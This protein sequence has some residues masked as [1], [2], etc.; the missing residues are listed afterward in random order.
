MSDER[1][2]ESENFEEPEANLPL[3]DVLHPLS[4]KLLSKGNVSCLPLPDSTAL[5]VQ[6]KKTISLQP[7][8]P[9]LLIGVVT[10]VTDDLNHVHTR[11]EGDAPQRS[12]PS[13][14][15]PRTV[16]LG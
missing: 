11:G 9:S 15:L 2:R 6:E 12:D 5:A 3:L 1:S 13:H 8:Y 14:E 10:V 7:P 4:H 16:R